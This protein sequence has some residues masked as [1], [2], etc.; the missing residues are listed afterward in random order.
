ML[1][2]NYFILLRQEIDYKNNLQDW[3]RGDTNAYVVIFMWD[4][5]SKTKETYINVVYLRGLLHF[6][7]L[8]PV[9]FHIWLNLSQCGK[10]VN[11]IS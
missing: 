4:S 1:I 7:L 9:N 10:S 5:L 11:I 2:Q 6:F 3:Y 8:F